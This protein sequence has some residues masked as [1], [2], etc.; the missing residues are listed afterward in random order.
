MFRRRTVYILLSLLAA[1]LVGTVVVLS[2]ISYYLSIDVAAYITED[3]VN[4]ALN[5]SHD[6]LQERVPRII[7]QTWKSETLPPN[8]ANL[9][10]GCREMMPDYEYMLWTDASAREFIAQHYSWFLDTFDGYTYPIQ[11]ADAIRYFV[12]YHYGG[13]YMDLDMGCLRPMDPLLVHSVILPRT[14]PVGVSNDLMF[15]E[16]HHPFMAQTIHNLM[17]FDFS[18]VLNYPNQR[19]GGEVRI[20]PKSLYGKNAKPGEAPNS[21]FSHFYGSSWHADD[22]AFIGFLGTWGKGLMWIGL[23]VLIA[24]L[25]RLILSPNRK[26][27]NFA[28]IGGYE[29]LIPRW[30]QKNGRWYLDLGLFA[31]PASGINTQPTSPIALTDPA[32]SEEDVQ[33]LPLYGSSRSTSP[34]PSESSLATE[35]SH[36]LGGISV[37]ERARQAGSRLMDAVFGQEEPP[38]TPSRSRR[39]RLRSRGVLF[40]LPAFLSSERDEAETLRFPTPHA[41]SSSYARRHTETYSTSSLPPE[42]QRYAAELAA[43]GLM[44]AGHERLGSS[45]SEASSSSSTVC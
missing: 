18:W 16:K 31:L 24:G 45:S 38:S 3:E 32:E 6:A 25:I 30:T 15:A 20:L 39:R 17:K 21:F 14:K 40:F 10:Q 34:T 36:Q 4:L 11:R 41:R 35:P 28:R 19:P 22:A 37:V 42:K 1:V 33:L 23:V 27:R 8:W 26:P 9:S 5:D 2:S 7:H 13:V 29:V 44:P 43:A 12:L